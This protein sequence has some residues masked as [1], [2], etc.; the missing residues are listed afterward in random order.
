MQRAVRWIDTGAGAPRWNMAVDAALLRRAD[1]A[2]VLRFYRWSPAAVSIGRFQDLARTPLPP[3]LAGQPVV[4]RLTGGGAIWHRD[5][6][7]FSIAAAPRWFVPPGA[8]VRPRAAAEAVLAA[9]ACGL[10]AFGIE[11]ELRCRRM[12]RDVATA[13]CFERR[14]GVVLECGGR[15][16]LGCAQ[17]CTRQRWLLHAT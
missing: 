1:E 5:D 6:L 11:V 9:V 17:R 15:R 2:A 14:G 8:R 12:E 4:R 10:G 3:W 13:L 16:L 7:T